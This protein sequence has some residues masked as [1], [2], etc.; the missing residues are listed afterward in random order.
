MN[1]DAGRVA[2]LMG[3]LS[4]EREVS[5]R[6][7]QAVVAALERQGIEVQGIDAGRDVIARLE[8]EKFARVF[9]ALHGRWGEDGVI[10]GALQVL[11]MSYTGSGVLGSALGMDKLR[12][13]QIWSAVDVPTAEYM[14]MGPMDTASSVV[15]RLGLPLI[16]KPNREGSSIGISK[17]ESVN[18]LQSA[19]EE[20]S[21]YDSE[22]LVERWINGAEMTAAVIG[23][24]ELPLIRLET[25][26]SFY[27][28]E[29]K[30]ESDTT[31]YLC[32]C[33]L[34]ESRE[35]ELREQALRA[36]RV[37][38]C[39]GWGR[40][41]FILGENDVPY[42]LEVNTVPGLTDHS[43]VPMAAQ[44]AGIGFDEMVM[45]ILETSHVRG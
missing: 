4:A 11:G 38:G 30:Y 15:E 8:Q 44:Q 24:L 28:Y 39:S 45:K 17:V 19:W 34:D 12:C 13:K 27:D 3:G 21:R 33:G 36:F 14:M 5:L 18:E 42:F 22:V 35:R 16:V 26:R 1:G 29:A 9:I 10:Q 41:D 20:A 2:V 31:R 37:L 40:V 32:P 43:L 6:S 7:G 23:D 25:P